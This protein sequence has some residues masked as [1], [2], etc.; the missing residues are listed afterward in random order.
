MSVA[1]KCDICGKLYE[2]SECSHALR[3]SKRF[4]S[5]NYSGIFEGD[6]CNHCIEKLSIT[7]TSMGCTNGYLNKQAE[8]CLQQEDV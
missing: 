6:I 2:K 4:G 8:V 7:L 5:G 1:L 3:I